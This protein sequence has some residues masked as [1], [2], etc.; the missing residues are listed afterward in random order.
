M[1]LKG[2]SRRGPGTCRDPELIHVSNCA[3]AGSMVAHSLREVLWGPTCASFRFDERACSSDGGVEPGWGTWPCWA[4]GLMS[5][6]L[7]RDLVWE[8]FHAPALADLYVVDVRGP[9]SPIDGDLVILDPF[10]CCPGRPGCKSRVSGAF[11][12][13]GSAQASHRSNP[14]VEATLLV[15]RRVGSF[16]LFS[17][18]SVLRL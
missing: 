9:L 6:W 16:V 11:S 7:R 1:L 12:G 18:C 17:E 5:T 10:S 13:V 14:S 4:H 3:I 8:L 2:D 15:A